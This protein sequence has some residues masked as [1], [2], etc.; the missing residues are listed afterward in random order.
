MLKRLEKMVEQV[1]SCSWRGGRGGR[2]TAG[3]SQMTQALHWKPCQRLDGC[4]AGAG[5][6]SSAV[7]C[8]LL[9]VFRVCGAEC[10]G[11]RLQPHVPQCQLALFFIASTPPLLAG[12]A[13]QERA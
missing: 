3:H 12:Q 10:A 8:V 11:T 9:L 6:V 1:G 2:E 7:C 13:G 5:A 4:G